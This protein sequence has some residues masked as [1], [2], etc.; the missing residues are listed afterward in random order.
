MCVAATIDHQ[1]CARDPT[2]RI[3]E[4]ECDR[5]Q[6]MT[7]NLRALGVEVDDEDAFADRG[8][9]SDSAQ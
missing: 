4:Q 2:R 9:R 5:I 1:C 7:V 3:R 6:A 8:E